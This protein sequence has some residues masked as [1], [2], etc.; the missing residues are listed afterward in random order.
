M[1]EPI[2]RKHSQN[3]ACIAGIFVMDYPLLVAR[4][5]EREDIDGVDCW[6]GLTLEFVIWAE[7]FTAENL[8]LTLAAQQENPDWEYDHDPIMDDVWSDAI[9][10]YITRIVLHLEGIKITP[11]LNELH[12]YARMAMQR[13]L[14]KEENR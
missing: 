2:N 7:A 8:K 11:D 6:S 14:E 1:S 13:A 3:V 5:M 10:D 4:I 9:L 12:N